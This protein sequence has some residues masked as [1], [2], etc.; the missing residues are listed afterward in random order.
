MELPKPD[1]DKDQLGKKLE[2]ETSSGMSFASQCMRFYSRIE[3]RLEA[4]KKEN[5]KNM[6]NESK[7]G[8]KPE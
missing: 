1:P 5:G 4:W 8:M 6:D 2:E 7:W 3:K